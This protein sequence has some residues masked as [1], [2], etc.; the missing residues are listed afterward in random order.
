MKPFL[1]PGTPRKNRITTYRWEKPVLQ[2]SIQ[3]V[4]ASTETLSLENGSVIVMATE[5]VARAF[6]LE[7]GVPVYRYTEAS[8]F[9]PPQIEDYVKV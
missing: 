5:G 4:D 1:R 9:R 3:N 8:G 7:I 6:E 2:A